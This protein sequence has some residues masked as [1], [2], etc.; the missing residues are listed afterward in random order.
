[1][2]FP[3]LKNKHKE[4][5]LINP[6]EFLRYQRKIKNYPNYPSPFGVIFCYDKDLLKHI[7]KNHKTKKVG[8]FF[9]D[10]Y[11]LKETKNRLGVMG[12][13]GIGAPVVAT[14]MEELIAFGV[15]KFVSVGTAG[16]IQKKLKVGEIILCERAIRDE[17]T[18]HH[19]LKPSK[20]VYASKK[21]NKKIEEILK[22]QRLKYFVGTTWTIDTPYRETVKEVKKYQREGVLTVEMEV[23]AIFAVAKYRKIE[24]SAI[25][26]IS[27]Y[28]GELEWKPK[29]HLTKKNLEKIFRVAKKSC[30]D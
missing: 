1:M 14:L 26:T 17:G 27:D 29:F 11:L 2:V 4:D 7:V 15:K 24:A 22:K 18:S 3:N 30:L 10:F 25:L 5:S 6:Q 12:N 19:Y 9:G 13:F 16:S 21:L 20:Y 28:L 23:S 8:G